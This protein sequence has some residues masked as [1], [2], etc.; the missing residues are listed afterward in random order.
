[1][2]G[3]EFAA[4]LTSDTSPV[5]LFERFEGRGYD[6]TLYDRLIIR[7]GIPTGEYY[8]HIVIERFT[9]TETAGSVSF[10]DLQG[11]FNDYGYFEAGKG[12]ALSFL[13]ALREFE[14]DAGQSAQADSNRMLRFQQPWCLTVQLQFPGRA[15]AEERKYLIT[16][17]ILSAEKDLIPA[18]RRH[19]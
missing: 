17:A 12:E 8:S 9:D 19:E 6:E 15:K 1:M 3:N 5:A 2:N 16:G 14:G 13:T 18:D 7:S 10:K 11:L 4:F